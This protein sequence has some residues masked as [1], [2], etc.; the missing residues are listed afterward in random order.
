VLVSLV[1][2]ELLLARRTTGQ[3]L[4]MKLGITGVGAIG[5]VHNRH[6]LWHATLRGCYETSEDLRGHSQ[7]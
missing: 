1:Y 4:D 6:A 3:E 5:T 7:L 2:H